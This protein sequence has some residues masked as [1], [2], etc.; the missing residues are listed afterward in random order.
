MS[1]HWLKDVFKNKIDSLV[2][3]I[4]LI[5]WIAVTYKSNTCHKNHF[6]FKKNSYDTVT[7]N[8]KTVW[9]SHNLFPSFFLLSF[10]YILIL[11]ML[12]TTR[13]LL[14]VVSFVMKEIMNH[15][16]I[17]SWIKYFQCDHFYGRKL[18][19]F[20][21]YFY[22]F[23]SE[24]FFLCFALPIWFWHFTKGWKLKQNNEKLNLYSN[25]MVT[26]TK[27]SG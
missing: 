9:F 14:C 27:T 15:L 8:S 7:T 19:S 5:G 23:R 6:H 17:I 1:S 13:N 10:V 18:Y 26:P 21:W 16:Q 2:P 3:D 25:W 11:L 22:F 4:S 24:F 20:Y 12:T